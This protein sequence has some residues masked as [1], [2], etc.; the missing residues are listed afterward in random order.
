M[1]KLTPSS[2]LQQDPEISAREFDGETVM[3]DKSLENYFGLDEI[4]TRIWQ[5]LEQKHTMLELCEKLTQEYNV[6]KEQCL[7][8]ITPFVEGLLSDELLIIHDEE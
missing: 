3:M 5:I 4:G 6:D 2:Y 8:D 7:H 1:K